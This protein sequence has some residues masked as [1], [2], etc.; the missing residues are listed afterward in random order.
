M[1]GPGQ[2][3]RVLVFM[4][5]L[6]ISAT[7]TAGISEADYFTISEKARVKLFLREKH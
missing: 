6:S 3:V 2:K 1:L 7:N 4:V 5:V